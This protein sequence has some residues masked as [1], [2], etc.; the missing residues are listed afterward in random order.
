MKDTGYES[1]MAFSVIHVT[2]GYEEGEISGRRSAISFVTNWTVKSA[3][4]LLSSSLSGLFDP[5]GMIGLK[6][7]AYEND[8]GGVKFTSAR[9]GNYNGFDSGELRYCS[10]CG[11]SVFQLLI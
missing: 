2:H 3:K 10:H 6:R 8:L 1:G 7:A 11:V 9:L 4:R 5:G